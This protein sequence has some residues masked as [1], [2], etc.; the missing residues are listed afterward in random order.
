MD[1]LFVAIEGPEG[2]GKSSLARALSTHIAAAGRQVVAVREPGGTPVA[3][4]ARAAFLDPALDAAPLAEVFLLLAA[5]ADL[6]EKVIRPAVARGAVVLCDRFDLSTEAYQ[7]AGRGLDAAAIRA[8]NRLATGG[9]RPDLTLVL[10]VPAAVGRARQAAQG[11]VPDRMEQANAE[12]HERVVA[13]FQVAT[14]PG[15]VHLDGTKTP[16]TVEQAAWDVVSARLAKQSGAA[17]VQ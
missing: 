9:L 17:R 15:V 4:A 14:G 8:A 12:F 2:A 5:R 16:A 13:A 6:V 10:D 7:I 3:E 1:G 11:K